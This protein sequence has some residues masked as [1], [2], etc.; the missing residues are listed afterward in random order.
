MQKIVADV[1]PFSLTG[2]GVGAFPKLDRPKVLWLGVSEGTDQFTALQAKVETNLEGMGF[3]GE[4]RQF[5]PHLTLGR[6]GPG[7]DNGA[8]VEGVTQ[9][10]DF[11]GGQMFVD[12]VVVYASEPQRSGPKYTPLAHLQLGG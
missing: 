10:A 9:L 5:V 6:V 3:R 4:N 2:S 8:L 1:A 11:A 12:E 7:Q